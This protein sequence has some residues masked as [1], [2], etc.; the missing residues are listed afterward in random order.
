MKFDV[1]I[2]ASQPLPVL[3]RQVQ[4]AE[5]LGFDTAWIAD[6]HLVCRELWVTLAACAAGTS[7]IRLGPGIAVPHTR[8]VSVTASAIA[9][10]HELAEGRVVLGIGTGGSAAETMGL[11][12]GKVA[13][14]A[15]LESM[16]GALRR[17][18]GRESIRLDNGTDARLAWLERAPAIPLFL[19]GSGP[20]ML[21][22]A[23]RLG[24]GAI[25]YSGVAPWLVEAA[26]GCVT[27]GA[28]SV[29]RDP[30]DLD[31][32]IWAPTS[33]APDRALARDH[34]RG[35]VASA[36]RHAFPVAWSPE[37]R[38]VIDQVRAAYDSYQ[39]A[40]AASKHRLLVTDR[41]VDLMALAGRPEE[42]REQVLALMGVGGVGRIILLP[43][44]PGQAFVEREEVLRLF[45]DQVMARL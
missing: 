38:K 31:V 19:A 30:G 16:A 8:H 12:V 45:A 32:A 4:L 2:L 44:V 26:L 24:D 23:G 25:M 3:V 41:F 21:D 9:T 36:L 17:L 27:A 42:V 6:T 7:R 18:L 37:D 15:T 29:G 43:Q 28:R 20:R 10:L 33:I 22:A 13:R 14:V 35:R 5:S 40:S 1:G 34:V 11:S 39:H